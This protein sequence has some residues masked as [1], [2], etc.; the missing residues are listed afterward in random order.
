[1]QNGLDAT[2]Q[3]RK[4]GFKNLIVGL[5][6]ASFDEEVIEFLDCGADAVFPKPLENNLLKSLVLHMSRMG[7]SSDPKVKWKFDGIKLVRH[8]PLVMRRNSQSS[9]SNVSSGAESIN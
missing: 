6:G 1:L 9:M 3:L 8:R 2:V 5:T 4:L 7:F